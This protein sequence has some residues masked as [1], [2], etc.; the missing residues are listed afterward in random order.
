MK[1]VFHAANALQAHMIKDLLAM[2]GVESQLLGELPQSGAV[3]LPARGPVQV[4]V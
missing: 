4:S 3:G 1:I 2:Q